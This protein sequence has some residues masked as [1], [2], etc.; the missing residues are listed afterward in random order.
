[1]TH[2][3]FRISNSC[4]TL[5]YEIFLNWNHY[6]QLLQQ[7]VANFF[8]PSIISRSTEI[9]LVLLAQ[10][11]KLTFKYT[12]FMASWVGGFVKFSRVLL[13]ACMF[14]FMHVHVCMCVFPPASPTIEN[15]VSVSWPE[16]KYGRRQF[17][18]L[19]SKA[20]HSMV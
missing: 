10:L 7:D 20:K 14:L 16:P 15:H 17:R 19:I 1:M 12:T 6:V 9:T 18:T 4:E 5:I 3:I 13:W 2:D 11:A 8:L